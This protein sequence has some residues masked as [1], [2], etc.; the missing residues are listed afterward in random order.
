VR[1][2]LQSRIVTD[3]DGVR[4]RVSVRWTPWWPRRRFTTGDWTPD[5][6]LLDIGGADEALGCLIPFIIA[7]L[8]L[9]VI[10][11]L[12]VL[13]FVFEVALLLAA[14]IPLVL[15]L[16]LAGIASWRIEVELEGAYE[17]K[18]WLLEQHRGIRAADDAI[19]NLANRIQSGDLRLRQ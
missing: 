9:A 17:Q 19:Y 5:P 6:L 12:P 7:F 4:W 8:V 11:L 14:A 10:A 18:R 15:L 13:V 2:P 16:A 3:P 1:L